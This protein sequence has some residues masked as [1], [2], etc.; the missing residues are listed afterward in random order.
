MYIRC[1]LVE[2]RARGLSSPPSSFRSGALEAPQ[3]SSALWNRLKRTGIIERKG[4]DL[5]SNNLSRV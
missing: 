4:L 3:D 5:M 2:A 1:A